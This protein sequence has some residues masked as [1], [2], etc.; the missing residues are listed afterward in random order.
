MDEIVLVE[1]RSGVMESRPNR[2]ERFIRFL[3]GDFPTDRVVEL[4]MAAALWGMA[5]WGFHEFLERLF[6]SMGAA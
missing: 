5:A 4:I 6:A 1:T 3:D 2:L